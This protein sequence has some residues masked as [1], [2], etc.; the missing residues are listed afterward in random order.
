VSDGDRDRYRV[1]IDENGLAWG[2]RTDPDLNLI[3]DKFADLLE[4]LADGRQV[5]VMTPAYSLECWESVTLVDIAYTAD[6]RV[7]RDARVRLARLFDK[8]RAIDPQAEDD[9]PAPIMLHGARHEE[10]SWGMTHA[11]ACAA[12]GRAMSCLI[13]P[14]AVCPPGWTIAEREAD[15]LQLEIH[16]LSEASQLP[17]FWRGIYDRE[18]IPEDAFFTLADSAFPRLIFAEDLAFGRFSGSYQ[19]VR[20]W[21]VRL[22]SALDDH[23]AEALVRHR[24]NTKNVI[25]EFAAYDVDISPDSP[26]THANAKAAAQRLVLY[27]GIEYRCEWHGKRLWNHDRVHF[28]LPISKYGDRVLIGIFADHLLT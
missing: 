3:V 1:V 2:G 7:S 8:C 14:V 24:G 13:G 12:G 11:L 4:P 27:D 21:L 22:L 10:P 17:E 16:L 15:D 18:S 9:I 6:R 5:A 26:N 23:F 19:E 28:S 20:P 25:A